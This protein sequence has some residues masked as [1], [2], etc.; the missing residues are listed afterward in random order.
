MQDDH[1]TYGQ[2]VH[3][4]PPSRDYAANMRRKVDPLTISPFKYLNSRGNNAKPPSYELYATTT[5]NTTHLPCRRL[6]ILFL[7]HQMLITFSIIVCHLKTTS[8]KVLL[9]EYLLLMIV[10]QMKT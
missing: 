10:K 5:M 8:M 4:M 9:L 1:L 6:S 3:S 2:I 7:S